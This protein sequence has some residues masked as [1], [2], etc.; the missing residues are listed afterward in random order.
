MKKWSTIG[1]VVLQLVTVSGA[2]AQSAPQVFDKPGRYMLETHPGER[3][4]FIGCG[5]GGGG[6]SG[7]SHEGH[8]GG[9]GAGSITRIVDYFVPVH[10]NRIEI[11]I[12][13]GGMGGATPSAA[14]NATNPGR[15]GQDALI[16]AGRGEALT[17]IARFRGAPGAIGNRGGSG[18]ADFHAG[19]DASDVN[20]EGHVGARGGSGGAGLDGAQDQDGWH[21]RFGE[22]GGGGDPNGRPGGKDGVFPSALSCAGGGGGGGSGPGVGGSGSD[23]GAA[24]VRII[25]G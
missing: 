9:G 14:K 10:V 1:L 18:S 8:G 2:I 24:Y 7:L 3:F 17:V 20:T 11:D 19:E 5:G 16:L 25:R 4:Q 15:D 13:F 21:N 22:A 23:G 12:G 6:A